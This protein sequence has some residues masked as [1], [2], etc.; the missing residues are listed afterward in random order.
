MR[1]LED[2]VGFDLHRRRLG[3][4]S[5]CALGR[6]D[7]L[8]NLYNST[9]PVGPPHSDP[10]HRLTCRRLRDPAGVQPDSSARQK[11]GRVPPAE[12]S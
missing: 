5:P 9:L 4:C 1:V 6:R 10:I 2:V 11:R 3:S 8:A 7:H 12:D